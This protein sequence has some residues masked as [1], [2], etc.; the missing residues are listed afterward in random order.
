MNSVREM[1]YYVYAIHLNWVMLNPRIAARQ[2][3]C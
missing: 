3:M 1:I 2:D